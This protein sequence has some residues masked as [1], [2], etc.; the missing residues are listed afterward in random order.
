[1]HLFEENIVCFSE[2][3]I[4]VFLG[5]EYSL[6]IC[7]EDT[8]SLSEKITNTLCISAKRTYGVYLQRRIYFVYL[9]RGYLKLI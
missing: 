5:G 4:C 3:N 9:R 8:V 1:M 7:K 2:K 6:Y